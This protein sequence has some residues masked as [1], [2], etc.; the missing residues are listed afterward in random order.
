MNQE[1]QDNNRKSSE[2]V[3]DII[4]RMPGKT[5]RIVAV[6]IIFIAGLL[7]FFGWLIEYPEKVSGPVSITARQAPVRLVANSSGKLR[8]LKHSSD[9]VLEN[10][11]IAYIENPASLEDIRKI[12]DFLIN[13]NPD[14]L[15]INPGFT[16]IVATLS[17][18]ELSQSFYNFLNYLE[19]IEQYNKGKPFEKKIRSLSLLLKS[20]LELE[21]YYQR[22]LSTKEKTLQIAGKSIKR[23]SILYRSSAI[24]EQDI[25]RSSINYLGV[26]ESSHK[27]E[28][29][30][31]SL[32]IQIDDT[33]H[34]LQ[35]LNLEKAEAEQKLRIDL[36]TGYNEL[37]AGIRMWKLKYTFT[38]PI[39]G[40]LEYLNFWRENDFINAGS[41]VFSILPSDNPILGQIYLPS[42]GAGKVAVGQDV[43]I[44][45]DN[46]PYI[47]YG[48]VRGKVRSIS[49][50][51]NPTAG[52]GGQG[53]INTYLILIDLPEQLT[54]N[55][56][57]K[58][59]FGYEIRGIADILIRK[60]K[61]IVR[62]FD[63]LRYIASKK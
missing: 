14:S 56:D 52:P 27:M 63:N 32:K 5:G 45:L 39:N 46:Y 38:S 19:K 42:Q 33:R 20:Q 8:L 49:N 43:I 16:V 18:G 50:I 34:K 25:D 44:K 36:I 2:E 29:D 17:L 47:E 35:M 26:L 12:E 48:S 6:I 15:F 57:V 31:T 62:L 24:A 28:E 59:D 9:T 21:E 58:L 41:D 30:N 11:I 23:D 37:S 40:T 13:N 7:M 55:Y 61:L 54:T 10:E 1:S 3:Q 53:L 4:D 60:R 22:Q 51:A